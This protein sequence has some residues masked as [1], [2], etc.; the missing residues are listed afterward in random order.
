MAF[1]LFFGFWLIFSGHFDLFHISLGLACSALVTSVSSDLLFPDELSSRT[2]VQAW[3]LIRF[4]PWLLYQIVLANVH[5]VHLVL[6]PD[7]IRPQIVRFR[8]TLKSDFA[9]VA[10]GNAIT[11]TPGTVTMDIEG[12]EFCV[13]AISDESAAGLQRGDME[14]RIGRAFLQ[15]QDSRGHD[16]RGDG[17]A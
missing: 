13:H 12:G 6:R 5:V 11:L 3:R 8:T 16:P 7:R 2:M 14:R 15:D 17:V 1:L 4:A 9:K 10:L